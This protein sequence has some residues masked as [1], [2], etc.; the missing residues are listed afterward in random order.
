MSFIVH[1]LFA[2]QAGIRR[3]WPK[4]LVHVFEHLFATSDLKDF[5]VGM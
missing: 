5:I 2:W 4:D 3:L 1:L